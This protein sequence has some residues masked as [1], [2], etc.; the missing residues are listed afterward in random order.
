MA[1]VIQV[2]AVE[3]HGVD[4]GEDEAVVEEAE[5]VAMLV[6][7]KLLLHQLKLRLRLRLDLENVVVCDPI[8]ML[9]GHD[10]TCIA[11][12][13]RFTD[14]SQPGACFRHEE[15]QFALGHRF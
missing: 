10:L 3:H 1:A 11:Q 8:R 5:L 4:S 2:E 6:A 9:Q 13:G 7:D 14:L 12:E 15:N